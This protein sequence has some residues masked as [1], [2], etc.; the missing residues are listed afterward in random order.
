M[1]IISLNIELNRHHDLVLPFLKKELPEVICLQEFLEE[2]FEMYKKE[3]G[4]DGV[5]RLT[6]YINDK[7]HLES[8]G[9]K[10]GIAIFSKKIESSGYLFHVWDQEKTE[11]P[12][13]EY[14]TATNLVKPRALL[15]V[16]V[17]DS[18]GDVFKII[19][20]HL[21][22][23]HEGEAT[24]FQLEMNKIFIN[25]LK[26]FGEFIFCGDTNAPRGRAAFDTIA[27][28]FKDNIPLKYKYSLDPVLHRVKGLDYMVDCLFTT[29]GYEAFNVELKGGI[30]DHMAVVAEVRKK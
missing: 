4:M 19:T 25:Q 13:D 9:K 3:L 18:K 8:R 29:R 10:E 22:I 28:E 11:L 17:K 20:S 21:T 7:V 2:D 24:P 14:I 26:S 6:N 12:F 1:K 30:S 5:Y 23:T 15:W 16:D 27:K